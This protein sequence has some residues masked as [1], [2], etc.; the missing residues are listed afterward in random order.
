MSPSA[1][2]SVLRALYAYGL[3]IKPILPDTPA[4]QEISF[5]LGTTHPVHELLGEALDHPRE[6]PYA[7]Y[8]RV[9]DLPAF[10]IHI[11]PALEQ[12][13]ATS[14]VASLSQEIKLDFYRGGLRMIFERGR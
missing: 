14:P 10:L 7:W 1:T 12:R 2:P 4:F 3:S 5:S 11:A 8:I 6:P 9:K 13:L